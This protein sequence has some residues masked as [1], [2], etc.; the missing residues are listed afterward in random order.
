[1]TG[2]GQYEE[3]IAELSEAIRLEPRL[4]AAYFNRGGA[5]RHLGMLRPAEADYEEVLRLQPKLVMA[6]A[7]LGEVRA[8][9]QIP[10][11]S[12][13][14]GVSVE[15]DPAS[16]RQ[17]R[18]RGDALWGR[19]DWSGAL[20]AYD[21]AVESDPD[22]L[23]TLALRGWARLISG[24]PGPALD[25]RRWLDRRG[26]RDPL[27]PYMA[28]LG[29]LAARRDVQSDAAETFLS[30]GLAN[31]RPPD[32]PAPLFRFLKHT[33]PTTALIAAADTPDHQSE[34]HVVIGLDLLYRGER[35]AAVEHLRRAAELGSD[36]SIARALARATLRRSQ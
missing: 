6:A 35:T 18:T 15:S 31:T 16:A 2:L 26:W 24:R 20:G 23:E 3:A 1:M 9:L 4:V 28:L 5:Y 8:L 36:R 14:L 25:A 21:K 7:G 13:P 33:L 22:D 34:A 30:E 17:Q 10:T 27:A 12:A 32:W 19:G 29:V 11:R